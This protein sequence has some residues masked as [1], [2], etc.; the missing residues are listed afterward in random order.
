[1]EPE[2]GAQV[3]SAEEGR[4]IRIGGDVLLV[5]ALTGLEDGLAVLET[6]AAPGEPTRVWSTRC[7]WK[8][9]DPRH[10]SSNW[11]RSALPSRSR[12]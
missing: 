2:L 9:T 10:R 7:V 11:P 6:V 3:R 8:S 12:S 5:K 4:P 1:M